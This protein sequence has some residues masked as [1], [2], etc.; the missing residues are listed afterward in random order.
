MSSY[1]NYFIKGILSIFFIGFVLLLSLSF[2]FSSP[3]NFPNGKII[4]IKSGT[5]FQSVALE[6]KDAG[7]IRST[8][9]FRFCAIITGD[10]TRV[11]AGSYLFKD[12]ENTCHVL[13]RIKEGISGIPVIRV[14]IPEGFTNKEILSIFKKKIPNLDEELF[15]S[16]IDSKEG[17]LFPDTYFFSELINPEEIVLVMRTNFDKKIKE[18]LVPINNSKHTLEEIIIMA[19]IIEKEVRDAKDRALVSGILWKRIAIGMPLQVDASFNYLLGK[20]SNEISLA[21][22]KIDSPYNTYKHKGLPQGPIS[23]P[24]LAS[25][26]A[27]INPKVSPYLFYLSDNTGVTHYGKTFDEH[28]MNKA[29]YLKKF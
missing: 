2:L 25:I 15:S 23:N 17:Y 19:S 22:L 29:K 9:A 11:L 7:I 12:S 18:F 27:A 8:T 21:D 6:L 16:S 3:N 1:K 24:G 28:K 10:D 20:T 14:T 4:V 5:F 13:G 26:H